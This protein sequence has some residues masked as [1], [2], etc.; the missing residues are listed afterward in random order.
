LDCLSPDSFRNA[1]FMPGT[2]LKSAPSGDFVF[3]YE[4]SFSAI[5]ELPTVS[6]QSAAN[7]LH[8]SCF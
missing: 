4:R 3:F 6:I 2:A 8:R 7:S 5:E 1:H